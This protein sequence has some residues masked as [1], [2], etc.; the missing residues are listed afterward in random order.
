MHST[1][2][3]CLN[4]RVLNAP[5]VAAIAWAILPYGQQHKGSTDMYNYAYTLDQCGK[6]DCF[7]EI[8]IPLHLT[9]EQFRVAKMINP[10]LGE[11]EAQMLQMMKLR[12][13][14]QNGSGPFVVKS[15][16]ELTRE[17]VTMLLHTGTLAHQRPCG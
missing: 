11:A 12:T 4:R 3:S 8:S 14:F 10:Q 17:D 1:R 6:L 2:F 15:E 16:M 7:G 9:S 5:Y 13:I